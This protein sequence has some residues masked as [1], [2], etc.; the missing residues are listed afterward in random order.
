MAIPDEQRLIEEI[1]QR[2]DWYSTALMRVNS[3]VVNPLT[4]VFMG[5]G[6]FVRIDDRY[7]ILTAHHVVKELIPP[8]RLGLIL[9]LEQAQSFM[10]DSD[11]LT[12]C[13][14][15]VSDEEEVGHDLAFIEIYGPD[16]STV[17]ANKQFVNLSV[18]RKTVLPSPLGLNQGA[19]FIW[20]AAAYRNTIE[21]PERGLKPI[22]GL[23][24]LCGPGLAVKETQDSEHDYVDIQVNYGE[25]DETPRN[26][27]GYSG[28]G[29]WQIRIEGI[30]T[31]SPTPTEW[32]YSGVIIH[33]SDVVDQKRVLTC[34]GRRSVYEYAY[35]RIQKRC[36]Y[37]LTS[38]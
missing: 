31:D 3:N 18:E 21:P 27:R 23:H 35:L 32:I 28:G 11:H 37:R 30:D 19:W 22:I 12:I 8:F 33:Q 14:L 29:L 15:A 16:V 34:H 36:A 26:F 17:K 9:R 20:G 6:T 4:D 10:I 24:G 1:G 2:I 13:E 7:G 25:G 38:V 5:C